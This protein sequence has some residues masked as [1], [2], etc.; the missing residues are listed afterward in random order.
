[1]PDYIYYRVTIQYVQKGGAVQTADTSSVDGTKFFG[2]D[3]VTETS[4][5]KV[6]REDGAIAYE[7]LNKI[8]QLAPQLFGAKDRIDPRKYRYLREGSYSIL[9]LQELPQSGFSA[10]VLNSPELQG[11]WDVELRITSSEGASKVEYLYGVI[12]A[13]EIIDF[14][15]KNILA[16]N[17]RITS[18]REQPT[19]IIEL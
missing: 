13:G 12:G 4:I 2:D 11:D 8:W 1:M 9:T 14:Y 16:D 6:P 7:Y 18:I 19:Q 5:V 15:T 3:R 10:K 17:E